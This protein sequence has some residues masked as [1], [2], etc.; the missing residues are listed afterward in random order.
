MKIDMAQLN[1]TVGD[2]KGNQLKIKNTLSQSSRAGSDLVVFPE[3]FLVGYPP[4]DLLERHWFIEK[5]Q[6]AIQELIQISE[7]FPNTGILFG[8]PL[9]T[10]K[11]SGKGL[12]NSA[13]LIHRGQMIAAQHKSLLPTYDVFDEMRYFDP[14]SKINVAAFKGEILGISICEDAWNDIELWPKGRLYP[15]DP[16]EILA[17]KG[18][19]LLINISASPFYVRKEEMRYRLLRNHSQ[20]HR[21]PLVFLNQV[22]GNDEL[23]FDG[24]SLCFDRA[25]EALTVFPSFKECVQGIDTSLPGLTGLYNPQDKIESIYKALV[26]GTRD[27]M[28]KCRFSQALIGLSGGI[29][30]AVTCCLAKEAIGS[31]NVLAV[32]MPSPYSSKGSIEDSGRLAK[33]LGIRF[34]I[35][36]IA[37]IY[38][39]YLETLKEHFE[40]K[41]AEI[42]E[43]NIQARIRGNILMALSNK[44]GYLVLS[45]GNKS[46]LAVGYCTLYGDMSGGLAVISDVPKTVVYE[47]A[48]YINRKSQIIPKEIIEKPPSAE[49]KPTQLDQDTLPPYPILDQI[50]HYYIEEVC[51]IE[52]IKNLGFDH[53]TVEWVIE[54]VE[55][56]EYKRKQ[57]APG[58]KVTTKSFGVGRRI[59]IA[60]KFEN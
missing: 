42:T 27:Y 3:L 30:S 1:P 19:T 10:G 47:L 8:A 13:V 15:Y 18:A 34:K 17:K 46:E 51:S 58:L 4:K 22:G 39:K 37:A 53:K 11:D 33:S 12:Y 29:D 32:S 55:K 43:E 21:L 9:R 49:L 40:G 31:K 57:A 14:A 52:E 7:E 25:G 54:N 2:I 41:E 20:K 24:S 45:T 38:H 6:Q 5:A 56:N 50:L 59:P 26:L 48:N 35:I 23:I 44:F 28:K 16:I 36:S 60:A